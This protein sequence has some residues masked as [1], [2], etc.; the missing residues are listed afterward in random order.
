MLCQAEVVPHNCTY[1]CNSALRTIT[2]GP[3]LS[4]RSPEHFVG[5]MVDIKTRFPK[6]K[7]FVFMDD[8]F[9]Y[10]D[11]AWFDAFCALV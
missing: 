3:Y 6:L 1:C 10:G 11:R 2:D 5:E 8:S 9:F 7:G 4:R